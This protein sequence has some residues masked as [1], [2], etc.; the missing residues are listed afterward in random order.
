[1]EYSED[2]KAFISYRDLAQV[3]GSQPEE[4]NKL[5]DL[6]L[7]EQPD[8][9]LETGVF[10]GS[11]TVIILEGLKQLNKGMLYSID[12]LSSIRKWTGCYVTPDLKDR[13]ALFKGKSKDFFD[14][15]SDQFII[16]IFLHDSEH[17]Q[18]NMGF[19]YGW[20]FKHIKQNG[21]IVS[22]DIE[23]NAAWENFKNTI[24]ESIV[25][26]FTIQN[27]AGVKIKK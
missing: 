22:H 1:M 6:I 9:V 25:S 10:T 2:L 20:A 8:I 26:S 4:N 3:G 17:T 24:K 16:D 15:F 18:E 12:N 7:E 13:W 23:Q 14:L 5:A 27:L 19:E 11:S 21:W